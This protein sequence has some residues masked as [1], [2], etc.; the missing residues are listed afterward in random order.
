[1]FW[2]TVL[3]PGSKICAM[4]QS[5]TVMHLNGVNETVS[6]IVPQLLMEQ[7]ETFPIQCR[8]IEHMHEGVWFRKKNVLTK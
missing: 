7:S 2:N 8:H 6:S 1:M 4:K 5:L 3:T